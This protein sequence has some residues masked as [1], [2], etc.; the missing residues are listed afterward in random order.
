MSSFPATL[1][2][3]ALGDGGEG[4]VSGFFLFFFVHGREVYMRVFA[5]YFIQDEEA[6]LVRI[7]ARAASSRIRFSGITS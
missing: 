5:E 6:G 3:A 1:M 2:A 4:M 7:V